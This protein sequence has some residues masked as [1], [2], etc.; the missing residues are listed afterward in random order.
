MLSFRIDGSKRPSGS[1]T[2][3]DMLELVLFGQNKCKTQVASLPNI[4]PETFLARFQ[5]YGPLVEGGL[6]HCIKP[7]YLAKWLR[8]ANCD[9]L[10]RYYEVDKAI[11][12]YVSD[13]SDTSVFN[14]TNL[15]RFNRAKFKVEIKE[16]ILTVYFE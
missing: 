10:K 2:E 6:Q 3:I 4:S 13:W 9:Q 11:T 1:K 15:S 8:H 16:I 14:E 12:P 5:E 7:N